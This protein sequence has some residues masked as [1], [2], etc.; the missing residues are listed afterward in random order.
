[1][2]AHVLATIVA[3][4]PATQPVPTAADATAVVSGATTAVY[5]TINNPS[6]YDIYVMSATSDAA[7]KVELYS[8]DKPVENMTVAAY[9]SLELKAGGMFLR[10]SDLKRELKAGESIT[11]SMVTDGGVTIV[12]TAA[13]T[14]SPS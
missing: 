5:L 9:G 13:V 2:I 11:V 3:F 4:A 12:A 10:L 7:G 6:M 1:V 8:A 14:S